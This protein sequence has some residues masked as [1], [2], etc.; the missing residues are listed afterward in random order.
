LKAKS[1]ETNDWN[2]ARLVVN[3]WDKTGKID[4]LP[5]QQQEL[6]TISASIESFNMV[7]RNKPVSDDRMKQYAQLLELRLIPFAM[8]KKVK[9]MQEMDTPKIW[10]EFRNSWK[11]ENPFRNRNVDGQR[12]VRKV[13]RQTASRMVGDLRTYL[14]YCV[15]NE[16]WTF[17]VH[18]PNRREQGDPR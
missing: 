18:K 10:A 12:P 5:E 4:S 3:H 9:F 8:A 13:G 14:N 2:K 1:A 17:R 15:K 16:W 11:D 7:Q 6:V